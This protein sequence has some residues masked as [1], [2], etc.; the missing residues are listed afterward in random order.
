M[1]WIAVSEN[2]LTAQESSSVTSLACVSAS[3]ALQRAVILW[4]SSQPALWLQCFNVFPFAFY[5]ENIS[6]SF[7]YLFIFLG[8]NT[9]AGTLM[10]SWMLP[11]YLFT[12]STSKPRWTQ[13]KAGPLSPKPSAH[14]PWRTENSSCSTS[15]PRES[16]RS[17]D[18]HDSFDPIKH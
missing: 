17:F 4:H 7:F 13:M 14:S 6:N 16:S 3:R 11:I 1:T 5:L 9:A 15:Y 10:L 2:D 12:K 18:P 8:L